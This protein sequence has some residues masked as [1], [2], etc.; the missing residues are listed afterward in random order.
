MYVFYLHS[1]VITQRC[2]YFYLKWH[3]TFISAVLNIL[4][5]IILNMNDICMSSLERCLFRYSA[6]F[7]LIWGFNI[8]CVNCLYILDINPLL[9]T[10][11]ANIFSNSIGCLFILSMKLLCYAKLLSLI[12]SHLFIFACLGRLEPGKYCYNLCQRVF[13]VC[14]LLGVLWFLVLH[15]GL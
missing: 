12:V 2:I 14:F 11:F 3:N 1:W 13:H 5:N 7:W 6:H 15:L 9:V 10:S 4:Q 8:N